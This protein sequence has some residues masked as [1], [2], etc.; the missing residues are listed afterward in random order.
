MKRFSDQIKVVRNQMDKF[1]EL[2]ASIEIS[3]KKSE[4]HTEE[5]KTKKVETNEL[6]KYLV[7]YG[8]PKELNELAVKQR[9]VTNKEMKLQEIKEIKENL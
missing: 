1:L 5:I 2:T 9:E 7:K 8:L 4:K 3:F 6:R